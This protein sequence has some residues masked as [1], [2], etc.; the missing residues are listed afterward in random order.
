M[1]IAG[2]SFFLFGEAALNYD[3]IWKTLDE[4]LIELRKK[5]VSVPQE[6][7]DDLKSARTLI[8]IYKADSASSDAATQ[9]EE[10]VRRVE[11]YVLYLAEADLGN[12]YAED[13]L[14]R[15]GEAWA[16]VRLE[17]SMPQSSK[18]ISG[19]PRGVYWIRLKTKDTINRGELEELVS[20]LELTLKQQEDDYVLISGKQE[21]IKVLLKRVAENIRGRE[22]PL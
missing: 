7:V 9:I 14:K 6:V 8:S 10:Y 1:L 3:Y 13:C 22:A 17:R 15:I 4:L 2:Y 12:E 19:V 21:T 11:S 18:F 20:S 16:M 5:G